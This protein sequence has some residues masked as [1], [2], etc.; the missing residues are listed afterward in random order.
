MFRSRQA[1]IPAA[2][3]G[4]ILT[5]SKIFLVVVLFVLLEFGPVCTFAESFRF[6]PVPREV[7]ETR[8]RQ[9]AGNDKKREATLKQMFS[10]RDAMIHIFPNN[11]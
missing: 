3:V 5:M 7:I 10:D 2:L 9:Y 4:K 1:S 8:L 6:K 11:R